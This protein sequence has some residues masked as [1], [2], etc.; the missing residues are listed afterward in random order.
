[1]SLF[2]NI[3]QKSRPTIK[4][5]YNESRE[6]FTEFLLAEASQQETLEAGQK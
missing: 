6:S 3:S 2:S 4:D 5:D 1:M